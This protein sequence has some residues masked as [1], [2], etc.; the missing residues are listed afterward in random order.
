MI[1]QNTLI[2][3]HTLDDATKN[4]S[5][6]IE[7]ILWIDSERLNVVTI[8]MS[9]KNPL[10]VWKRY[11]DVL[12]ALDMNE[13]HILKDDPYVGLR[14]SEN[15]LPKNKKQRRDA[16]WEVIEPLVT[17]NDIFEKNKRGQLVAATQKRTGRS[18]RTIYNYLRMYWQRGQFKNALVGKK[19]SP[20]RSKVS[21]DQ[22]KR[23][24]AT[25]RKQEDG[26]SVGI[27]IDAE[28]LK[29]LQA[30]YKNFYMNK[31]RRN[32]RKAYRMTLNEFFST[33]VK[34]ETSIDGEVVAVPELPDA[35]QLPTFQQFYYHCHEQRN[36]VSVIIA[37]EGKHEF[38]LN[39]RPLQDG[40]SL[41]AKYPGCEAELD[42][43]PFPIGLVSSVDPT[44]IVGTPNGYALIDRFSRLIMGIHVTFDTGTVADMMTLFVSG[45]NKVEYCEKYGV[46]I[47]EDQWPCCHLPKWLFT[48]RGELK[49]KYGQSLADALDLHPDHLP[50]GR[51]DCKGIVER[52]FRT[53]QDELDDLPGSKKYIKFGERSPLL[54]G[55]L[56]IHEF[57]HL[58]IRQVIKHNLTHPI[59]PTQYPIEPDIIRAGIPLRP[60][61]LWKW[62]LKY[63]GVPNIFEP[64]T[65]RL[66]LL[67][68]DTARKTIS[69][70]KYRD[71]FYT[72]E[73]VEKE[74]WAVEAHE[75]GESDV[76]ISYDPREREFIYLRLPGMDDL[77]PCH[78]KQ[79]HQ[80]FIH[81]SVEETERYLNQKG[82]EKQENTTQTQAIDAQNYAHTKYIVAAAKK[83]QQQAAAE[84]EAA[85][86]KQT[87]AKR[88]YEIEENREHELARERREEAWRPEN[89]PEP[90]TPPA[91]ST[92]VNQPESRDSEYVPP[93]RSIDLLRTL[94]KEKRSGKP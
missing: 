68:Q 91:Q 19:Y 82:L 33:G 48:D 94:R 93:A 86:G 85:L 35:D 26:S 53:L 23:G 37:R 74:G 72:C 83:R 10:P 56:N 6:F 73:F 27:N 31:K 28:A 50:A 51:G 32:L 39:H 17:T 89:P 76:P 30:G 9:G 88:L 15:D 34:F 3:W 13:A 40:L 52:I 71:L 66:N 92:Q 57:S 84:K 24:R 18:L 43:T 55:V 22:K 61:E 67:P 25:A 2:V 47:T 90:M 16:L 7:R 41:N 42:A 77:I 81:A 58:L 69:G 45:S 59:D 79:K 80:V 78:L 62:G 54:D 21:S 1:A 20:R 5:I 70:I 49:G 12:S 60:I 87:D 29:N 64:Q 4:N 65:L 14:R 36:R 44:D 75:R 46:K 63:R 8:A 11:V 38:D